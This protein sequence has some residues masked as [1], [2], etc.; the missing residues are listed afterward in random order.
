MVINTFMTPMSGARGHIPHLHKI[1]GIPETNLRRWQ[2][3]LA[4]DRE[5]RPWH[6][7]HGAHR[8][9]CSPLQETAIVAFIQ[10]NF[11]DAGLI[12]TDSDFRELAMTAFL[13]NHVDTE[14]ALPPFQ[15][16]PGFIAD[17]KTRHRL[18]SRKIHYKRRPAVTEEQRVAW[19]K[20]IND[21]ITAVDLSR[22]VNC[23]ETSWLLHPKG[24]LTSAGLG[25][26][27][28]QAKIN[29]DEKD[30]I[31]VMASVT[32][33]GGKLPLAFIASGKTMRVE[34]SQIGPVDG[35]WRAHSES[36]WQTSDTFQTYLQ[37]LRDVMGDGP[38]HLLL[39]SYSA[40]RTIPVKATAI[41]LGITLHFIPPGLTDELQPLDRT[42]FGV[43]KS[44]AK[45]LFHERFRSN[46]P[47]RR[48]K[49]DGVADM[50][51][52]WG[53]LGQSAIDAAWDIYLE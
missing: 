3:M 36:G 34:E 8:R 14:D 12:F 20:R 26:Q 40:H 35:H 32:A 50:I 7:H 52:A 30:C 53:L 21:L 46:P 41:S 23:D 39:D 13:A 22:I 51:T 10:D 25:C 2:R 33:S 15:C 18:T 17:F 6:T 11:I 48:T 1:T 24:I 28:V 44:Q 49:K 5:W 45:R 43:L 4:H 9:I 27:S 37:Q 47:A 16:S 38:I 19:M 29:G 42:L 31:T